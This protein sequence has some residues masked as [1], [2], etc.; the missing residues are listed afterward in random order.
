MSLRRMINST[1]RC[2]RC[3]AKGYGTCDCWRQCSCGWMAAKDE[4]CGNPKT[5]RCSSKLQFGEKRG[6]KRRG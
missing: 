6:R 4:P 5:T 3:G 2:T 1:V